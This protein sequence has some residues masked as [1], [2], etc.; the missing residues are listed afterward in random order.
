ME[1]Y[2]KS[3]ESWALAFR[4]TSHVNT[5]MFQESMFGVIKSKYLAGI[6]KNRIDFL[7]SKL[8]K[9]DKHKDSLEVRNQYTTHI[10]EKGHRYKM[11]RNSHASA[12]KISDYSVSKLKK[13]YSVN[14][15]RVVM[16]P[17]YICNPECQLYCNECLVCYHCV[18]CTC[19]RYLST[20][21]YCKHIH[22]LIISIVKYDACKNERTTIDFL[23]RFRMLK[24]NK[25]MKKIDNGN[26]VNSISENTEE[27]PYSNTSLDDT[28]TRTDGEVKF[29]LNSE[30]KP[31]N[32][33]SS[34]GEGINTLFQHFKGTLSKIYSLNKKTTSIY[35]FTSSEEKEFSDL[36]EDL[37]E[38]VNLTSK[39]KI[40]NSI[41]E[42]RKKANYLKDEIKQIVKTE[43]GYKIEKTVKKVQ[44][45]TGFN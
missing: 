25:K 17:P 29:N 3:R 41:A 37:T 14:N 21:V 30:I 26:S 10:E 20:K 36:A 32:E 38:M 39:L 40:A 7:V 15:Y 33:V 31:R 27:F 13:G 16:R 11:M 35:S 1:Y 42:V 4:K 45:R 43:S 23:K 22:V 18:S 24:E 34:R 12:Q 28:D 19:L 6:K 9:F 2:D 44:K 8:I 5:N